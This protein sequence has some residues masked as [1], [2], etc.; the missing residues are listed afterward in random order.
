MQTNVLFCSDFSLHFLI[1]LFC[2]QKFPITH[3]FYDMFKENFLSHL[4]L[5]CR[6]FIKKKRKF[7]T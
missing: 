6:N 4:F 7:H 5:F 1:D 2:N 3:I